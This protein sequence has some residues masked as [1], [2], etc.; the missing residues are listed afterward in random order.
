MTRE[1]ALKLLH[2]NVQNQNLRRHCYAVEAV[3]RALYKRLEGGGSSYSKASEDKWG[4]AGLL[5]DADYE[6]TKETAKTEHTKHVLK[7]L[8][9]L[10]TE[11]DIYDAIA[12]HAWGFVDGAPQPVTKMQWALYACDELTGLIVAVA[13]VKPD[14][15]LA[16]VT[17]ESVMKKWDSPSFAAGANRKLIAECEPRLGIPRREFVEIALT[18][19]QGIHEDLGL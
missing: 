8:K 10:D 14:R 6:L 13:L 1:Q 9:D 12:A 19:M 17:V 15:K 3:M 18:A 4:M 5:H 11:I 7:W 16:S 2:D